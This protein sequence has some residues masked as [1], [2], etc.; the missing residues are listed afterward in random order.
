ME[1]GIKLNKNQDIDQM[2]DKPYSSLIGSLLYL[3]NSTRPDI[4]FAVHRLSSYNSNPN[5]IHWKA[6]KRI[7]KYLKKTDDLGL[8]FKNSNDC[9]LH[10]YSDSDWASDLDTRRSTTGYFV[11]LNRNPIS[12]CS[13]RQNTIALSTAEAEYMGISETIKELIWIKKLLTDLKITDF[14][15]ELACDNQS[16]I[17][18]SKNPVFHQRTKHIDI[19]Y[20]FIREKIQEMKIKLYYLPTELMIAD[21]LT[22]PL[23][24]PHFIELCKPLFNDIKLRGEC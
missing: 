11:T 4:T 13:K 1:F 16:A 12:W 2:T 17:Q 18:I 8:V 20:H 6:A 19:R 14:K 5:E 22:K 10:G 9:T 7:L 3:S 21:L 23:P 15:T 24:Y